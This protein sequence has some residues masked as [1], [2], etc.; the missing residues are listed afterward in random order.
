[1]APAVDPNDDPEIIEA[2]QNRVERALALAR[3]DNRAARNLLQV[4]DW[5]LY[6]HGG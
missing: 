1:M 3:R 4:F 2:L 6:F 5:T